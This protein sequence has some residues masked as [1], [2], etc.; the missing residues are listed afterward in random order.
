[1]SPVRRYKYIIARVMTKT[2]GI[3]GPLEWIM[4]QRPDD[5]LTRERCIGVR[6]ECFGGWA[7]RQG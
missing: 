7:T 2:L 3:C 6:L 1:M 4:G 5:W